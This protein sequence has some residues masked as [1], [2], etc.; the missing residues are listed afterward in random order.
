MDESKRKERKIKKRKLKSKNV[1][2]KK[3]NMKNINIFEKLL[4]EWIPIGLG[5]VEI[6]IV[7]VVWQIE[8]ILSKEIVQGSS[9]IY[10]RA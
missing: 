8:I 6:R 3:T 1:D 9:F 4:I 7:V 5:M 2:N 10:R